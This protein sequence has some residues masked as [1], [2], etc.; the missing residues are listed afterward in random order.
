MKNENEKEKEK[1][2]GFVEVGTDTVEGKDR[3]GDD[4][5]TVGAGEGDRIAVGGDR[6]HL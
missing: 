6:R 2:K 3:I 5:R 1:E 4:D